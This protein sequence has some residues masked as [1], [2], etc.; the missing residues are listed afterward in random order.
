MEER[1]VI[2]KTGSFRSFVWGALVGAGIALLMAPRTGMEMRT[3]LSD[4][5]V[6]IKDRAVELARDTRDKAQNTYVAARGK[7]EDTVKS[8][9]EK[10]QDHQEINDLKREVEIMEEMNN[11]AFPL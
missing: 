4:K 2:I 8:F 7:V 3:L 11:R 1:T 5:G 6:E 10:A 9:K